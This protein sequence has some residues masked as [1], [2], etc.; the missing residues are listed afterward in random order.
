MYHRV[1]E[2]ASDPWSLCV[3]PAHF[4]EHLEVLQ[5]ISH[6]LGLRS[7]SRSLQDGCIAD[8]SVALT[9][10]DGYADNLHNA[11][12]LLER[13]GIPATVFL[14][15][16][17]IGGRREFWWDELDRLL[18]QPG[19]LPEVLRLNI[20]GTPQEWELRKAACYPEDLWARHCSWRASEDPPTARHALYLTLWR[21][22][23]P[24]SESERLDVLEELIAW[25]RTEA[26]IRSKHR[27]LSI[28]EIVALERGNLVEIGSH[29][30]THPLLNKL[31]AA[32]QR[33]EVQRSKAVL[34][35]ILGHPVG[36]FAY[37]YGAYKTET[38]AVVRE[39]GFHCACSTVAGVVEQ[40]TDRFQLPRV[41][42][43][44]WDGEEFN[45]RLCA[46]LA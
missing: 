24:L 29:T 23:Q 27:P 17:Y 1:A 38:V 32:R 42:V 11:K 30:V 39:S 37:P 10:D 43:E 41:Q 45:R 2:I 44:N 19:T 3:A 8:L 4:A 25:S 40:R 36:S 35:E 12:P 21:L 15:S 46:W 9:F 14:A 22:L 13:Y 26:G 18:L 28:E 5:K 20:N 33:D 6:P 7:L 34:E 16:G 31:S